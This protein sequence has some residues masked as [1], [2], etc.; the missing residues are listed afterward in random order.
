M[1]SKNLNYHHC[2]IGLLL[3]CAVG[4]NPST[5]NFPRA[6]VEGEVT[7]NGKPLEQGTV[8]FVPIDG[9]PG[10]KHAVQVK[11]GMFAASAEQGPVVGQ[12][13]IEIESTDNGGYAPDDEQAL[14][15]LEHVRSRSIRVLRVPEI[16]NTRSTLSETVA[17]EGPNHFVSELNSRRR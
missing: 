3:V 10:P 9:T 16:Y 8:R 12:H 1:V 13:R 17:A 4:C 2:F 14:A 5:P 6:A 7:F 15:E 11:Q